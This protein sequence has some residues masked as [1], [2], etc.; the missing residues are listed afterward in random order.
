MKGG[1]DKVGLISW[2]RLRFNK[3]PSVKDAPP[4]NTGR[5]H[6][7]DHEI[8][9]NEDIFSA[10]SI[11]SNAIGS[12]PISA[13]C[14]FSPLKP[15]NDNIAALLKYGPNSFQTTF[16]FIR[17]METLRNRYGAAYVIKEYNRM[18][19][20][21]SLYVLDSE[22][23]EPM[24]E[25]DTK[26]LYYRIQTGDGPRYIH[27]EHIIAVRHIT[28][29]GFT[30]ISPIS[31]LKNTISYDKQLKEFSLQQ[32]QEGLNCKVAITLDAA[33]NEK[34]F[35]TYSF[36]MS[37]FKRNG[38]LYLGKGQTAAALNAG[39]MI[40][41]KV[42]EAEEITVQKVARVFGIPPSKLM[43]SKGDTNGGDTEDILYLKDTILPIIRQYEQAFTKGL[44]STQQRKN[45]YEIKISLNGFARA[46]MSARGEFYQKG[47][48]NG[49]FTLNDVRE[50]ED[51]P[52]YEFEWANKPFVSRDLIP[53]DLLDEYLQTI[54]K[55]DVTKPNNPDNVT[56]KGGEGNE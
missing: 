42:F 36:F 43:T 47:L 38:V 50:L 45:G 11:L 40:D 10:I 54:T 13:Q 5:F 7:S 33:L 19:E 18:Y 29:D 32:I 12:A 8:A 52:P 17:L 3:T 55:S 41:P 26:E 44:F 34:D 21:E 31:V 24:M 2:L 20:V 16:D 39:S 1:E 9:N 37:Q 22:A 28:T 53:V 51:L 6:F 27:S 30:P 56:L 4:G 35:D 48:R 23:V 15:E 46:S 49:W 14:N 25:T